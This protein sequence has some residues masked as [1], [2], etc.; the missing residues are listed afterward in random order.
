MPKLTIWTS[1]V[2]DVNSNAVNMKYSILF[3]VL[4]F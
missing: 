2:Q 3:M 1:C 4:A